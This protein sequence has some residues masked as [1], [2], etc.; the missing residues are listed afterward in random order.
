MRTL[1]EEWAAFRSE[2][3]RRRVFRQLNKKK[4][5][6]HLLEGL[7]RIL[8]DIDKAVRIVRET[9]EEREVVPNLMIGFGIDEV[10]A[11][12]VAEIKL[13]HINKEYILKRTEEVGTLG[14]E[15]SEM[16]SILDDPKKINRIIIDELKK[17]I[18][19]YAQPRKSL[20]LMQE[21]V[22]SFTE[23]S[24]VE[25]YP[26]N[27]FFSREGYFK[28][29]T[30]QS[31]RMSSEHDLKEGDEILQHVEGMGQAGRFTDGK[32]CVLLSIRVNT[33][34]DCIIISDRV[35]YLIV[36]FPEEKA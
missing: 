30:P 11:E 18:K 13:R 9:Q 21:D 27:L 6:L 4:E 24:A 3:V 23:E 10:Q 29:I 32:G 22:Q 17:V 15:I 5:K 35:T 12:Y 26:V 34:E 1:I 28:K 20:L 31:Y 7:S 36:I 19:N 8:L 2:C 14:E 33:K 16:E 25:N